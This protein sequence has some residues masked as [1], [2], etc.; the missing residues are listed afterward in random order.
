MAISKR[1]TAEEFELAVQRTTR[2]ERAV[3]IAKAVMVDGQPQVKVAKRYRVTPGSVSRHVS[4]VWS[5]HVASQELPPGYEE[6]TAILPADKV[7]IVRTWE[8]EARLTR[9]KNA[10]D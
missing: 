9:L 3:A 2:Q 10:I 5:A 7:A 4:A 1:L 8:S 6:V